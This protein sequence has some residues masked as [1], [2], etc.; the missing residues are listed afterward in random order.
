MNCHSLLFHGV[1]IHSTWRGL[2]FNPTES[3][4]G[5]QEASDPMVLLPEMKCKVGSL[6]MLMARRVY[7]PG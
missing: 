6:N 4:K 3:F 5:K 2:Y 7:G 1:A